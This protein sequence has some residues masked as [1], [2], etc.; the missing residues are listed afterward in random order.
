MLKCC[1][2]FLQNINF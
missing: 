1:H 2:Q